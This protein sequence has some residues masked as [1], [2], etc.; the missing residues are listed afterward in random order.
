[1]VRS[2][3]GV[4]Q[5]PRLNHIL[6][7]GQ[8]ESLPDF[9]DVEGLYQVV[10]GNVGDEE[11]GYLLVLS[12]HPPGL[13]EH[14]SRN[15]G[16]AELS[17]LIGSVNSVH[18]LVECKNLFPQQ[19]LLAVVV[20]VRYEGDASAMVVLLH[21]P[22]AFATSLAQVVGPGIAVLL[23]QAPLH[24]VGARVGQGLQEVGSF[25]AHP[26]DDCAIVR[27]DETIADDGLDFACG[28][29]VRVQNQP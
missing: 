6:I 29:F 15:T 2:K 13:G 17:S 18:V 26:D 16:N 4:L 23:D 1:M 24:N 28:Q 5:H 11:S 21:L 19:G 9:D 12:G 22:G 7:E 25:L 10:H 3:R 14:G 8:G 27:R 20:L